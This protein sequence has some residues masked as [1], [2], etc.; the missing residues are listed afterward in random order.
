MSLSSFRILSAAL[1]CVTACLAQVLDETTE[2]C[3]TTTCASGSSDAAKGSA[4][5]QVRQTAPGARTDPPEKVDESDKMKDVKEGSLDGGGPWLTSESSDSKK[6]GYHTDIEIASRRGTGSASACSI[7]RAKEQPLTEYGFME[8]SQSCCYEDLKTYTRRLIDD[9]GWKVC[10]EG[11]LSGLAPFYSC[12][13]SPV[14]LAELKEE[15]NKALP[16]CNSK[17]HWL[18]EKDSECTEP[19]LEC[20]V[21]AQ[22][23]PPAPEPVATGFI[24]MKVA[25]PS[26]M[27]RNSKALDVL[28]HDLALALAVDEKNVNVIIGSGPLDGEEVMSNFLSIPKGQHFFSTDG[29]NGKVKTCKVFAVYSI[30]ELGTGKK[31]LTTP[32]PSLDESDVVYNLMHLDTTRL[33]ERLTQDVCDVCDPDKTIGHVEVMET[34]TC[35]KTTQR[36]THEVMKEA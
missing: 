24:A 1:L 9:L 8:V 2:A 34:T 25:N 11:G 23:G 28:K 16:D 21:S 18:Q 17:C 26:E 27:V 13:T 29:K 30:Q 20:A 35:E 12:P 15:L 7:K 33:G 5:L 4:M 32:A 22:R 19:S 14:T 6:A 10:D 31:T 36:C 3:T